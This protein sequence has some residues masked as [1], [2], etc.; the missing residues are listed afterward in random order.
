MTFVVN[1]SDH[2]AAETLKIQHEFERTGDG[3]T[4]LGRRSDL[5]DVLVIELYRRLFSHE[6]GEPRGFCLLALGGY[7]RRELFPCSDIDLLFLSES[8]EQ[9]AFRREAVATLLREL[10]DLRLR[11]GHSLHSLAECGRLYREN[12]EFNVALLDCRF[13]AGDQ[14]LYLRL[15]D[16]VLP[17]F[18]AR[19]GEELIRNLADRA[20]QRHAK[21]SNTIF[22]LEPNVK[23]G[24]G[25]LRDYH[26]CRWLTQ[27]SALQTR[28]PSP[29][30]ESLWPAPAEAE[31]HAAFSLLCSTR[32]FLHYLRQ[33]DD[34]LLSY[35]CQDGACARGIAG[36]SAAPL[37]PADWMRVYFRRVRS[38]HRFTLRLLDE[39][40][41]ARAG[42]YGLFQNWRSRLSNADFSVLREMVYFRQPEAL[43]A[44]TFPLVAVI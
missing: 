29:A 1:L 3:G 15:R 35:E 19:D 25:G 28:K 20:R 33:R 21:F 44:G 9:E 5:A 27:I 23:E 39:H 4:V 16:D 30:P 32:C 36:A 17:R 31:L 26:V 2:Y 42:L 10:W 43:E 18:V 13:L 12:L 24:P 41:P 7:G 14:Q 11:V 34:N 6:V 37:A 8:S 38:I 22:H 40:A